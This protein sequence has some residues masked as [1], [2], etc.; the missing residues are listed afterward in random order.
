M[1]G[2]PTDPEEIEEIKKLYLVKTYSEVDYDFKIEK[3]INYAL[4]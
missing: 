4:I 2:H 3:D 1:M